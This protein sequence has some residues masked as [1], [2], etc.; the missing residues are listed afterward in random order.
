MQINNL[1][2]TN[3]I[4][5]QFMNEIRDKH[6]QKDRMRFRRNLERISEILSYEMSKQLQFV[7]K[8]IETPLGM[9]SSYEISNNI[10]ICSILRAGLPSHLGVLNYFDGA[11]NAFISAYRDT[12]EDHSFTIEVEYAACPD[13]TDKTLVLVDPM[14]AT[15]A[16]MIAVYESLLKFGQPKHV[17]ILSILGS[18]DGC[19][20]LEKHMLD[21]STLWI[22]DIDN[23]LNTKNYIIPGLGDAGDLSFGEKIKLQSKK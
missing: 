2:Q 19:N 11:E 9:S 15:G 3:S 7:P 13:L 21:S 20:A 16:S 6:I 14:L 18:K 12:K 8:D 22:G 1:S 23:E 10:V 17:H 4:L 5:T